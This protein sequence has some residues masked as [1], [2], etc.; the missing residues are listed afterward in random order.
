MFG[1]RGRRDYGRQEEIM[2]TY[3]SLLLIRRPKRDKKILR[4][5]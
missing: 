1:M 4:Q 2:E 5:K 3:V